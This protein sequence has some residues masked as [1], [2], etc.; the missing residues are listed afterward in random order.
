MNMFAG[1]GGIGVK[2]MPSKHAK[3]MKNSCAYCHMFEPKKAQKK[4]AE[5]EKKAEKK[6]ENKADLKKPQ[7]GGHTFR[8]DRGVCL[9]CHKNYEI[10]E[11]KSN[12]STATL[13]KQLKELLEKCPDKKSKAYKDAKSNYSMVLFDG[14]LGIHNPSYAR[15]LLEYSIVTLKDTS[16]WEKKE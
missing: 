12:A 4:E 14:G 13:M 16:T 15:A 6:K 5:K 9:Q 8:V 10:I 1:T 2:T 7:K 11:A 3:L